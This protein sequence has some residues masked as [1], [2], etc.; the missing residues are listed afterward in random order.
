MC[1][2][3]EARER[4][5]HW[6]KAVYYCL[7]VNEMLELLVDNI[8]ANHKWVLCA[9]LLQK[10]N[11]QGLSAC[12]VPGLLLSTLGVLSYLMHSMTL[13]SRYQR[14]LH[15]TVQEPDSQRGEVT[16]QRSHSRSGLL[17]T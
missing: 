10:I 7:H 11:E 8:G 16:C 9:I 2:G 1:K 3:L 4:M 6:V 17:V 5:R 15:F 12:F 13:Y 14:Y